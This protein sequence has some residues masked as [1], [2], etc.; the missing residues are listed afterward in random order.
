MNLYEILQLHVVGFFV[1]L[2]P[3]ICSAGFYFIL[4]YFLILMPYNECTQI[5]YICSLQVPG[6]ASLDE[7]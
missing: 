4:S 2:A 5:S 3:T 7:S 6:C 1:L